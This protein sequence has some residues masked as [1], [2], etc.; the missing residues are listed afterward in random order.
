ML[1]VLQRGG[2]LADQLSALAGLVCWARLTECRA[3]V[4]LTGLPGDTPSRE[5]N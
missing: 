5:L 3:V 2:A 1:D 4:L